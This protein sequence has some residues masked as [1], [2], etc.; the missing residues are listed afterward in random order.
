M[1]LADLTSALRALSLDDI[2][3]VAQSL[4]RDTAGD[5]VDA[6]HATIAIDRALR[7]SHRTRQAAQ[8]ARSAAQAV[9]QAA[10][11][12]GCALPDPA[13]THVARAAAEIARGLVAGDDVSAE[14]SHLMQHWFVVFGWVSVTS[15]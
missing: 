13:V 1:D 15:R 7:H 8:A 14:V 3:G 12:Q 4:D 2:H 9:Q 5:E 10:E 6:W 11:R